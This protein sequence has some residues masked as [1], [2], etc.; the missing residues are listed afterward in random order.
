LPCGRG[1]VAPLTLADR[2]YNT[3]AVR[4]QIDY[5]DAVPI[6]RG[7]NAIK[8]M[9]CRLKDCRRIATRY[10]KLAINFNSTVYLATTVSYWL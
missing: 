1:P 9:L 4:Q 7:G 2:A 5:Q 8:R 6:Y 3:N 10:D